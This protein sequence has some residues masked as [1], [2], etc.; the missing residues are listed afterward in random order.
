[1]YIVINNSTYPNRLDD[2]ENNLKSN[3]FSYEEKNITN[4]DILKEQV[5]ILR[6]VYDKKKNVINT[7]NAN[8]NI[9]I[10]QK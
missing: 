2:I 8:S 3:S 6:N 4:D 5:E 10:N 1:M 9:G 7:N